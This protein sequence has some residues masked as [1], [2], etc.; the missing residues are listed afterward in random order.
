M[1]KQ[2][3][4]G[5]VQKGK[6]LIDRVKKNSHVA[7]PFPGRVQENISSVPRTEAKEVENCF[8]D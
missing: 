8:F 2:Y 4:E 3:V 5:V 6:S 1:N 7:L